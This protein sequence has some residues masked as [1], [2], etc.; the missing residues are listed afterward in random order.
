MVLAGQ[1]FVEGNLE[2]EELA[3]IGALDAAQFEMRARE[4]ILKVLEIVEEESGA[5]GV[6]FDGDGAVLKF[7]E[8]LLDL[9]V[10]ILPLPPIFIGPMGILLRGSAGRSRARSASR[11]SAAGTLSPAA[12]MKSMRALLSEM[13][14]SPSLVMMMRIGMMLADA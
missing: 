6:R 4:G 8:V 9:L 3:A 14:V 7:R 13:G 12:V 11:G 5:G 1:I 2:G 10:P